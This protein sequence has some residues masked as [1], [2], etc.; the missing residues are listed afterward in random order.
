MTP[1]TGSGRK[2]GLQHHREVLAAA[3]NASPEQRRELL[4]D[5]R[6]QARDRRLARPVPRSLASRGSRRALA[7]FTAVPFVCG[8]VGAYL[9]AGSLEVSVLYAIG[10]VEMLMGLFLLRRVT[11]ELAE[12]AEAELDERELADRN[13]ALKIAYGA[14]VI[15]LGIVALLAAVDGQ[16]L[17]AVD[18]KAP[19][20]GAFGTAVLLPSAALA[21]NWRDL[22][23]D[24]R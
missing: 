18:W 9:P 8:V 7:L 21:W 13:Q 10:G 14:L 20:F 2:G 24:L 12:T 5:A 16:L 19:L 3:K 4:K 11:R 23:D 17:H 6:R 1:S 15:V 22:D